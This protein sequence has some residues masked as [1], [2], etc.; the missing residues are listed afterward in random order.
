MTTMAMLR[1]VVCLSLTGLFLAST[2]HA[3]DAADA[4][5]GKRIFVQCQ[6]CHTIGPNAAIRIGP[7]LNGVVGRKWASYPAFS[8]SAGLVAGRDKGNAW[9]A[10]TLDK[11]LANPRALVPGTRMTFLGLA[12]PAQRQDVIAYLKTFNAAGQPQQ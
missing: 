4:Q 6:V 7:P 8:Y 10:A 5:A 9:D 2:A 1:R 3:A 11:W 12:D